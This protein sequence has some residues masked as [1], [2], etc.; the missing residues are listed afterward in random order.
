MTGPMSRSVAHL[1]ARAYAIAP[2]RPAIH[3]TN[4]ILPG[5][6]LVDREQLTNE[7]TIMTLSKR[8]KLRFSIVVIVRP[9]P[10]F[11]NGW[12]NANR[13]IPRKRNT[14]YSE[15]TAIVS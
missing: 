6:L 8:A 5:I 12:L 1:R 14:T 11:S 2:R 4:F 3:M 7:V 10:I 15:V 9:H 13:P